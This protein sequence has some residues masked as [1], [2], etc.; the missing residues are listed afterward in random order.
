MAAGGSDQ[1]GS[2][3]GAMFASINVTPMVDVTLVLLVIF[4][5]AAPL[6]VATP[7]IKVA[8]PKAAT[9]DETKRSSLALTLEREV[10]GGYKLYRNGQPTDE[11]AV[12]AAVPGLLKSDPELQAIV[13]ADRGIAYGDVMHV[14][15]VI[16]A[17]GVTKF[18]LNTQS[19]P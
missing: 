7:S 11:Q 3:C 2:G 10:S 12:R 19:G 14:V 15:D 8:L 16:K 9:G 5:V 13:A 4:M 17:L 1:D 18:A 6:I